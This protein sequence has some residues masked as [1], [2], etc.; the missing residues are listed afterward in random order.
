MNLHKVN[1][2]KRYKKFF[3]K[4]ENQLVQLL[5]IGTPRNCIGKKFNV[6]SCFLIRAFRWKSGDLEKLFYDCAKRNIKSNAIKASLKGAAKVKKIANKISQKEELV[7]KKYLKEG[8][9]LE[10]IMRRMHVGERR[11][12]RFFR[13][14]KPK[15]YSFIGSNNP[16]FGTSAHPNSGKGISGKFVKKN[17]ENVLFRSLLELKIFLSLDDNGKDFYLCKERIFYIDN[18][19]KKSYNPD[20]VINNKI[21]EI[22]PKKLIKF[23]IVKKK[24]IALKQYCKDNDEFAYGGFLTED[25]VSV[26]LNYN[27]FNKLLKDNRIK[28]SNKNLK[29]AKANIV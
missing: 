4:N 26:E 3:K 23:N 16:S 1:A 14:G 27:Y 15:R 17:G 28:F 29:R 12:K 22:K 5:R 13:F 2:I 19:I 21:F 25:D 11:I 24:D 20:I 9:H 7:Y 8:L 10:E 6:S 18:K